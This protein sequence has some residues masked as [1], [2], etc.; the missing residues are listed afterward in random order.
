MI[1]L[2]INYIYHQPKNNQQLELNIV[3]GDINKYMN[4]VQTISKFLTN[5]IQNLNNLEKAFIS[6]RIPSELNEGHISSAAQE[7]LLNSV[8]FGSDTIK[9][10]LD[11]SIQLHYMN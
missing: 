6:D 9:D 1:I 11:N 3:G 8:K 5:N 4:M 7:K 10:I 2:K